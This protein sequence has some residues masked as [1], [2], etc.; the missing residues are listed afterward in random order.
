MP[1]KEKLMITFYTKFKEY[2]D[3]LKKQLESILY[4]TPIV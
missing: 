1:S 4:L 3:I 2:L